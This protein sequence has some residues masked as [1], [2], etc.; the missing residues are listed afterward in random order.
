MC[1]CVCLLWRIPA[2]S[3]SAGGMRKYPFWLTDP[4][5]CCIYHK[6]LDICSTQRTQN[7]HRNSASNLLWVMNQVCLKHSLTC[8]GP[9]CSS[10]RS[11]WLD[12]VGLWQATRPVWLSAELIFSHLARETGYTPPKTQWECQ[13]NHCII[14]QRKICVCGCVPGVSGQRL[15]LCGWMS[16]RWVPSTERVE[17]ETWRV[18]LSSSAW[19]TAVEAVYSTTHHNTPQNHYHPATHTHKHAH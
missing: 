8:V 18:T 19:P 3:V 5:D 14:S 7:A 10:D 13:N 12:W 11:L 17:A 4:V 2:G 9:Q 6:C 1:V 15:W 16:F